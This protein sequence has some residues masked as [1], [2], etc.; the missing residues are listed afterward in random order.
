MENKKPADKKPVESNIKKLKNAVQEGLLK[1]LLEQA[2]S[3]LKEV[4]DITKKLD[5]KEKAVKKAKLNKNEELFLSS[6]YLFLY[7]SYVYL[8]K[9]FLVLK[10]ESQDNVPSF[11]IPNDQL[12]SFL[13]I[14]ILLFNITR[15]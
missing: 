12:Y 7:Q 9:V 15:F 13:N 10:D 2:K 5:E 3:T 11:A 1:Q 8:E 14:I 4:N 6:F